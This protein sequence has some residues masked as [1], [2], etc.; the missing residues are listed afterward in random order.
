[1]NGSAGIQ[2]L[3]KT[4][5][6]VFAVVAAVCAVMAPIRFV[7]AQPLAVGARALGAK[8]VGAVG[9]WDAGAGFDGRVACGDAA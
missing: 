5:L 4:G 7:S 2:R 1:M 6:T 9:V 3:G 8:V